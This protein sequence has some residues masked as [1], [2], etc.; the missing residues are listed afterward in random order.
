MDMIVGWVIWTTTTYPCEA[1]SP[2]AAWISFS[3]S[4]AVLKHETIL[5]TNGNNIFPPFKVQVLNFYGFPP[6]CRQ[7]GCHATLAMTINRVY[8][9]LEADGCCLDEGSGD[10]F[11]LVGN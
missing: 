5:T 10:G 9:T 4:L 2:A 11:A 6:A 7:A 3:K 8:F 1:S